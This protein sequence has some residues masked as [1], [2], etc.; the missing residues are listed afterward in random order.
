[1]DVLKSTATMILRII[2]HR[3]I[4]GRRVLILDEFTTQ[5]VAMTTSL[6]EVLANDVFLV[7]LL[8]ST[9]LRTESMT[10]LTGVVFV[11][12][13]GANIAMLAK[14]LA[15]PKFKGNRIQAPDPRCLIVLQEILRCAEYHIFFSNVVP[16]HDMI[17]TMADADFLGCVKQVQVL[18]FPTSL[19]GNI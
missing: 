4:T 7:E 16:A 11:R 13:T 2:H 1:M 8:A 5:V 18:V 17:A 10:H 15:A 12:P 9:M 19:Y 14:E 3:A 6:T